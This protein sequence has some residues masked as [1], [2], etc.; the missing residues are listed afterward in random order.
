MTWVTSEPKDFSQYQHHLPGFLRVR[1]LKVV[2]QYS[3]KDEWVPVTISTKEI[4]VFLFVKPHTSVYSP[5]CYLMVAKFWVQNY[6]FFW[7]RHVSPCSDPSS[8]DDS[9]QMLSNFQLQENFPKW[10]LENFQT[11]LILLCYFEG[12]RRGEWLSHCFCSPL[13]MDWTLQN[14]I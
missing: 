3:H 9:F 11:F 6:F 8:Q 2:D 4:S 12:G 10:T 14:E 1:T 5:A 7:H 13:S